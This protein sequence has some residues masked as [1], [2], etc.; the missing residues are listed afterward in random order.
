MHN[1]VTDKSFSKTYSMGF[2]WQNNISHEQKQTFILENQTT[3]HVL[4]HLFGF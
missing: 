3:I 2:Y 1:I 4:V